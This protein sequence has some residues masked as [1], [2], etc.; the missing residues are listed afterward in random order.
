MS[1]LSTHPLIILFEIVAI[2]TVKAGQQMVAEGEKLVA[3]GW[4]LYEEVI[5]EAGTGDLP[6]LLRSVRSS[7][8]PTRMA[9][10]VTPPKAEEGGEGSGGVEITPV[11]EGGP[12]SPITIQIKRGGV[13]EVINTGAPSAML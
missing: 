11:R 1:R 8:T 2:R 5:A 4:A 3:E 7:L 6:Q 9:T 10:A 12:E 13:K